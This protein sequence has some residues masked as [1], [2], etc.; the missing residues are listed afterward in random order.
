MIRLRDQKP[1]FVNQ[2]KKKTR[3]CFRKRSNNNVALSLRIKKRS[4]KYRKIIK[5]KATVITEI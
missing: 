5:K 3:E 4:K 1:N 2:I